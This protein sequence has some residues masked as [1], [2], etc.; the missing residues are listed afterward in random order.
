MLIQREPSIKTQ[1]DIAD[2]IFRATFVLLPLDCLE[3]LLMA[4]FMRLD[5]FRFTMPGSAW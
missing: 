5:L 3:E 4:D 1:I 2:V